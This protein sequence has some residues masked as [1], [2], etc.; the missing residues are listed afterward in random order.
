MIQCGERSYLCHMCRKSF[1]HPSKLKRHEMIHTGERPY[2]CM[3]GR[4]FI[5]PSNLKVHEMKHTGEKPYVCN[6]CSKPFRASE[7]LKEHE[8][9]H[10]G[11][12]PINMWTIIQAKKSS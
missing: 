2:L 7:H 6:F 8:S 5:Q 1:N 3:C 9:V 12:K 4:S 10:H 11:S